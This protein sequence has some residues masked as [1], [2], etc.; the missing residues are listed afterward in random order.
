MMVPPPERV[1]GVAE[2]KLRVETVKWSPVGRRTEWEPVAA[3]PK[4][5][6]EAASPLEE[7]GRG[8]VQLA[9]SRHPPWTT[10]LFQPFWGA[11]VAKE[12]NCEEADGLPMREGEAKDSLVSLAPPNQD[13]TTIEPS[14]AR[15][16]SE[17]FPPR[18][19]ELA[20][21]PAGVNL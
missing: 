6:M 15:S 4:L 13:P 16:K 7:L 21:A 14:A 17:R 8:P 5:A 10:S 18:E 12:A 20:I 19:R 11:G 1:Y 2:S 9:G 3:G